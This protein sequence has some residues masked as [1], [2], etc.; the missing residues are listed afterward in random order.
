VWDFSVTERTHPLQQF[1]A[2]FP[3]KT[4]YFGRVTALG[5]VDTHRA[6]SPL[7]AVR[8]INL[9]CAYSLIVLTG[10]AGD[11]MQVAT[12]VGILAVCDPATCKTLFTSSGAHAATNSN[13]QNCSRSA[14]ITAALL[15][16]NGQ[17]IATAGVDNIVRVWA[18]DEGRQVVAFVGHST[19]PTM[20]LWSRDSRFLLSGGGKDNL[21]VWDIASGL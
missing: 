4:P 16:P 14:S 15:S 13:V 11:A 17:Y 7:A 2:C 12:S 6:E 10:D 18:T 3:K 20:L 8:Y 9:Q 5:V 21:R 1:A 19:A